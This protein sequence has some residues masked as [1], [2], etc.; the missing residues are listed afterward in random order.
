MMTVLVMSSISCSI[1]VRDNGA[2]CK[3]Y[4]HG[5]TCHSGR[6]ACLLSA[7]AALPAPGSGPALSM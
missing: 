6:V 1:S 5:L 4:Q 2:A 3:A 7:A